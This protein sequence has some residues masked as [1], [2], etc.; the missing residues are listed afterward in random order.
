MATRKPSDPLAPFAADHWPISAGHGTL[1][2]RPVER[3][4]IRPGDLGDRPPGA[5]CVHRAVPSETRGASQRFLGDVF[6]L[7]P[8]RICAILKE[9]RAKY[10]GFERAARAGN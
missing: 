10:P 2:H 7:P 8:S 5:V 9:F 4:A 1:D 3:F 6:D